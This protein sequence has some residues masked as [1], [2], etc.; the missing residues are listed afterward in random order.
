MLYFGSFTLL[1]LPL[2]L[3]ISAKA[4]AKRRSNP[5]SKATNLVLY[6][7][8]GLCLLGAVTLFVLAIRN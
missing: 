6:L 8:A 7:V 4:L 1:V 3:I 2:F 5:L